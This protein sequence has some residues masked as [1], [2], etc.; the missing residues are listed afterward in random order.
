MWFL[1]GAA[2][3]ARNVS[4]A[5]YG[6]GYLEVVAEGVSCTT[7]GRYKL[8]QSDESV[9]VL[10]TARPGPSATTDAYG[11]FATADQ[12]VHDSG[13]FVPEFNTG[14]GIELLVSE[15]W[16]AWTA[17]GDTSGIASYKYAPTGLVYTRDVGS[18]EANK[19]L[20]P[21][22]DRLP[23]DDLKDPYNSSLF[24]EHTREP[25][26]MRVGEHHAFPGML[27][28][29]H[30][31]LDNIG[32]TRTQKY[33]VRPCPNQLEGG[34][35]C[36]LV[37]ENGKEDD[38]V[39]PVPANSMLHTKL[40]RKYGEDNG[41]NEGEKALRWRQLAFHTSFSRG[42]PDL[43][44]M[45]DDRVS[46]D[47]GKHG[48]GTDDNMITTLRASLANAKSLFG[49]G[50]D[51]SNG[52]NE[53]KCRKH[54]EMGWYSYWAAARLEHFYTAV[55]GIEE[56]GMLRQ[57]TPEYDG[58]PLGDKALLRST[59][60]GGDD[61]DEDTTHYNQFDFVNDHDCAAQPGGHCGFGYRCNT[62]DYYLRST[63]DTDP[64]RRR[65]RD[66]CIYNRWRGR[67]EL[68]RYK[69]DNV[70]QRHTSEKAQLLGLSDSYKTLAHVLDGELPDWYNEPYRMSARLVYTGPTTDHL[71][72]RGPSELPC[73]TTRMDGAYHNVGGDFT[74]ACTKMRATKYEW[75][76]ASMM[77]THVF[78][79]DDLHH[80]DKDDE[81]FGWETDRGIG[82]RPCSLDPAKCF[83]NNRNNR[84]RLW[85]LDSTWSMNVDENEYEG[86]DDESEYYKSLKRLLEREDNVVVE[87]AHW[88]KDDLLAKA[89][90]SHG[91]SDGT[92]RT[93]VH[94]Q[95]CFLPDVVKL[96]GKDNFGERKKKFSSGTD[97]SYY[98]ARPAFWP[99]TYGTMR[100]INADVDWTAPQGC[101]LNYGPP[102][103]FGDAV[104]DV[105]WN[106]DHVN[107]PYRGM[108]HK[109]GGAGVFG[110]MSVR[111]REGVKANRT[112]WDSSTW[113]TDWGRNRVQTVDAP[114]GS[115][116]CSSLS[117]ATHFKLGDFDVEEWDMRATYKHPYDLRNCNYDDAATIKCVKAGI[118]LNCHNGVNP[119]DTNH[120]TFITADAEGVVHARFISPDA[121]RH[122]KEARARQSPNYDKANEDSIWVNW[123][124]HVDPSVWGSVKEDSPNYNGDT[125]SNIHSPYKGG[126]TDGILECLRPRDDLL[127]HSL[128]K[129][130]RLCSFEPENDDDR[131]KYELQ[132]PCVNTKDYHK[133]RQGVDDYEGNPLSM[134][135]LASEKTASTGRTFSNPTLDETERD[136]ACECET[137]QACHCNL[138]ART[139]RIVVGPTNIDNEH[140][141]KPYAP[142]CVRNEND[143]AT[144]CTPSDVND[145]GYVPRRAC[146]ASLLMQTE[147][148]SGN[149]FPATAIP[150]ALVKEDAGVYF[151]QRK[152]AVFSRSETM[153]MRACV[154]IPG[155]EFCDK[156]TD[157]FEIGSAPSFV[158]DPIDNDDF[159]PVVGLPSGFNNCDDY[160]GRG[161]NPSQDSLEAKDSVGILDGLAFEEGSISVNNAWNKDITIGR[162]C[163]VVKEDTNPS[164]PPKYETWNIGFESDAK[165]AKD[166]IEDRMG[167]YELRK[168]K[169]CLEASQD[170]PVIDF[171]KTLQLTVPLAQCPK[172]ATPRIMYR[173]YEDNDL[174]ALPD[175]GVADM[176]EIEF[177]NDQVN[178]YQVRGFEHVVR[179]KCLDKIQFAIECNG[180]QEMNELDNDICK[181]YDYSSGC[182]PGPNNNVLFAA[183]CR[184]PLYFPR[185]D[186]N[187]PYGI[188]QFY[189]DN[190][191]TKQLTK[192]TSDPVTGKSKTTCKC[193]GY[194][195]NIPKIIV[196]QGSGEFD[197]T[198]SCYEQMVG[199]RYGVTIFEPVSD[200]AES[201]QSIGNASVCTPTFREVDLRD[202]RR[203]MPMHVYWKHC[204]ALRLHFTIGDSNADEVYN[205]Q[206]YV[207]VSSEISGRSN[208]RFLAALA[209]PLDNSLML[210]SP[211]GGT[212]MWGF[213]SSGGPVRE[214]VPEFCSDADDKTAVVDRDADGLTTSTSSSLFTRRVPF[215]FE[216]GEPFAT[217]KLGRCTNPDQQQLDFCDTLV[218]G[219]VRKPVFFPNLQPQGFT[220]GLHNPIKT[221]LGSLKE[222]WAECTYT[223]GCRTFAYTGPGRDQRRCTLYGEVP[224]LVQLRATNTKTSFARI[225]KYDELSDAVGMGVCFQT[226]QIPVAELRP[227][228]P[229]PPMCPSGKTLVPIT[230]GSDNDAQTFTCV[231]TGCDPNKEVAVPIASTPNCGAKCQ[232]ICLGTH[233]T[234]SVFT[235]NQPARWTVNNTAQ[236]A[237]YEYGDVLPLD[238]TPRFEFIL[239][240]SGR[241]LAGS[242]LREV[243][244]MTL[245]LPPVQLSNCNP[246]HSGFFPN[247]TCHE[248]H[249]DAAGYTNYTTAGTS[250]T[251]TITVFDPARTVL[252]ENTVNREIV[253]PDGPTHNRNGITV[254]LGSE[255]LDDLAV[256]DFN[257]VVVA[258]TVKLDTSGSYFGKGLEF[259]INGYGCACDA[260]NPAVEEP[261]NTKTNETNYTS[262]E[263]A[264]N[265]CREIDP[266]EF[267]V[268]GRLPSV[269]ISVCNAPAEPPEICLPRTACDERAEYVVDDG[270]LERDR[271]CERLNTCLDSEYAKVDSTATTNRECAVLVECSEFQKEDK[272]GT[273]TSQFEC[274]SLGRC[275]NETTF[276][277][278][279]TKVCARRTVCEATNLRQVASAADFQ[280]AVC[281]DYE[282]ICNDAQY[283]TAERSLTSEAECTSYT[284]CEA[285][286]Y[287]LASAT[288]SSDRTCKPLQT[289]KEREI[290]RGP[291]TFEEDA[292]CTPIVRFRWAWVTAAILAA[293]YLATVFQNFIED[294]AAEAVRAKQHKG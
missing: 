175:E 245:L 173:C 232:Q 177:V 294:R 142:S 147:F 199:S 264:P 290:Y 260:F 52:E 48:F 69:G 33:A 239:P 164:K 2:V 24:Q 63:E 152:N 59:P 223:E 216:P 72:D 209:I 66:N 50:R 278:T 240:E 225:A 217:I 121:R 26:T 71:K 113:G 174:N 111:E 73:S 38:E 132:S 186:D 78:E 108:H 42:L 56:E 268:K 19:A 271:K 272:G 40:I 187:T 140:D 230:F 96:A 93:N 82:P 275:T 289:C 162:H 197:D 156:E 243:H 233:D 228:A 269:S 169:Q 292:V 204:S 227:P 218:P 281:T 75:L 249:V 229:S 133:W 207:V 14:D 201:T 247:E 7:A 195:D 171:E 149:D 36:C 276:M 58:D 138:L 273:P 220:R 193:R 206:A 291:D 46:T 22:L 107:Y 23:R 134:F 95:S 172:G 13:M 117:N 203:G 18:I 3:A 61:Y 176:T 161:D 79:D 112:D 137:D 123:G 280:D 83:M 160:L 51:I 253:P 234:L 100:A 190:P 27:P 200:D 4:F 180:V 98:V 221:T 116:T 141:D 99:Y 258:V 146:K 266:T 287:T 94:A 88:E 211:D 284:V 110:C 114:T 67:P 159:A 214:L 248:D 81:G 263:R 226:Q 25:W 37:V 20:A 129:R 215:D 130:T 30:P 165:V 170:C 158:S 242:K 282:V 41:N 44:T 104:T 255:D 236:S 222:C 246:C 154:N 101:D 145:L 277:D 151:V 185:T 5:N 274:S 267:P 150:N 157:I 202:Y 35:K 256:Q 32:K 288:V 34:N 144:W 86:T 115:H 76:V 285:Q 237:Q 29:Q 184:K 122:A 238:F 210:A 53:G 64:I 188:P 168:L 131:K 125:L 60:P 11:V 196:R 105:F 126:K 47:A 262:T 155:G 92:S 124:K 109:Q 8:Q 259:N 9:A 148:W 205:N 39:N 192:A 279:T 91:S 10:G 235:A 257:F 65:K 252:Q 68:L 106:L 85:D 12:V 153:A 219:G 178:T 1:L 179:H 286:T 43:F 135:F 183:M 89:L 6:D 231:R 189:I 77:Q 127:L 224:T 120:H 21:F 208:N 212:V 119:M 182:Q 16:D 163:K 103:E 194:D 54:T 261:D 17:N 97:G 31:V 265:R 181:T 283:E 90:T 191:G 198:E 167:F 57:K 62:N 250:A 118:S 15:K 84:V 102:C 45:T 49:D 244:E 213:D 87:F 139:A 74:R 251:I 143:Q 293:G 70:E 80:S 28:A 166:Y 254:T 270:S 128:M 55:V 136:Y 241:T